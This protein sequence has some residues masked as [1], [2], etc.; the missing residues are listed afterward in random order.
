[1]SD[2]IKNKIIVCIEGQDWIQDYSDY[3]L[4]F[5]SPE[6]DIM[7][8]IAPAVREKFNTSIHDGTNYL[9]KTRKAVESRNIYIIPNSTAGK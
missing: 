7:G 6:N 3:G 9:Y 2:E 5:D 4:N 8:A 1:M